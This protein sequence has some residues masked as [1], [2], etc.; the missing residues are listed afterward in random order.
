M[1]LSFDFI[2]CQQGDGYTNYHISVKAEALPD[3]LEKCVPSFWNDEETEQNE[4]RTGSVA[5][6]DG[7]KLKAII[8]DYPA[9][10]D[11]AQTAVLEKL[12]STASGPIK[13]FTY[14]RCYETTNKEYTYK[15]IKAE[16]DGHLLTYSYSEIVRD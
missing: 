13:T 16:I 7:A 5:D 10:L 2:I 14:N 15:I 8:T 9:E 4:K 12:L 1:A 11:E 3:A 6:M